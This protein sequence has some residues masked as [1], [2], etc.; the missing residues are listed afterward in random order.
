MPPTA[1][2]KLAQQRNVMSPSYTVLT[3]HH[4]VVSSRN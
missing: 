3:D 1:N 2:E 4:S